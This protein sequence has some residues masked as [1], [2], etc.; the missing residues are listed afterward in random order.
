MLAYSV[1][2]RSSELFYTYFVYFECL[3]IFKNKYN[4][5]SLCLLQCLY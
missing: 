1:G 3:Y 4:Q 2:E 5:N